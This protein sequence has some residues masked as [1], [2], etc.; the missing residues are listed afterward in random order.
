MPESQRSEDHSAIITISYALEK[1]GGVWH[2][3]ATSQ[4]DNRTLCYC[5]ASFIPLL[6]KVEVFFEMIRCL[7]DSSTQFDS[8][9]SLVDIVTKCQENIIRFDSN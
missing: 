8:Q 1:T 4:S 5:F 7:F 3:T 9:D 6:K 2:V